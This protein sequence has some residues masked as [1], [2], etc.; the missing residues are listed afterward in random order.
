MILYMMHIAKEK[1]DLSFE[2]SETLGLFK[3]TEVMYI[4]CD[5]ATTI[6]I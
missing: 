1:N 6:Y 5:L 3:F 4:L 2:V